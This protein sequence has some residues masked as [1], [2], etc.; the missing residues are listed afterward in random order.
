[1]RQGFGFNTNLFETNVLNLSVVLGIVVTVVGDA[2]RS[3]LDQRRRIVLSA[4]QEADKTAR[5]S[6]NRLA[7]A[8]KSVEAAR[9]RAQEIRER[10]VQTAEQEV[11]IVRDRLKRDLRRIQERRRQA[12]QLEYQRAIQAVFKQISTLALTTAESTLL[13]IL[14]PDDQTCSKQKDLNEIYVRSS[15]CRLT[16]SV[17]HVHTS[18]GL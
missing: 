1:M 7:E 18:S 4:L 11:S 16:G 14:N 3:L 17:A 12:L 13:T 2:F 15:L 6:E 5:E 8:R 10:S 9:V